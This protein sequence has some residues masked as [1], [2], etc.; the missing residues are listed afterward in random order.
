ME[1][2]RKE[3]RKIFYKKPIKIVQNDQE[4]KM[5]QEKPI[6]SSPKKYVFLKFAASKSQCKVV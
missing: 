5:R 3:G 4:S 1:E 6:N 2:N